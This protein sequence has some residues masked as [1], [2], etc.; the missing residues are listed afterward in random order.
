VNALGQTPFVKAERECIGG[1]RGEFGKTVMQLEDE[2]GGRE[3]PEGYR[4]ITA[5]QPPKGVTADEE[6]GGHVCGGNSSFPSRE[7]EVAAQ[8]AERV[9]SGERNGHEFWH[10]A[11]VSYI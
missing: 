2:S 10:G 11:S 8:F 5:F 4:W 3:S 6:S 1:G 7:R 9:G